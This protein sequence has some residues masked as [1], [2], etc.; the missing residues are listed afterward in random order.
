MVLLSRLMA[1]SSELV[2][3]PRIEGPQSKL[4]PPLAWASTRENVDPTEG[5]LVL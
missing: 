2:V 4:V 1:V 3:H 5:F